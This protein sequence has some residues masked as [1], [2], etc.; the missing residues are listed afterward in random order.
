MESARLVT[1]SGISP[2]AIWCLRETPVGAAQA[3]HLPMPCGRPVLGPLVL[4][5]ADPQVTIAKPD[6]TAVNAASRSADRGPVPSSLRQHFGFTTMPFGRDLTPAMLHRHA[7]HTQAAARITWTI[8][9]KT[10]G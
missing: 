8:T 4:A 2:Q 7:S 6:S 5:P 9:Q 3:R 10:L 1:G